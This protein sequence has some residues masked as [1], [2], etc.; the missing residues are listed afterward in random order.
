MNNN[1]I[2]YFDIARSVCVIYI[3]CFWHIGDYIGISYPKLFTDITTGVLATFTF[4]SGLF[5]SKK[6]MSIC[7][8]YKR[9][10]S[11]F[12]FLF[13]IACIT[14]YVAGSIKTSSQLLLAVTG[15]SCFMPPQPMTLWYFCM[16]IVFYFITPFI[17]YK[18][19]STKIL[20]VRSILSFFILTLMIKICGGDHRIPQYLVFY[21]LGFFVPLDLFK[22]ERRACLALMGGCLLCVI[23]KYYH[24][25]VCTDFIFPLGVI[26]LLI[27]SAYFLEKIINVF[28]KKTFVTISYLSMAAYLFHRQWYGIFKIIFMKDGQF[29]PYFVVPIMI[30]SLLVIAWIIQYFYDKTFKLVKN[31]LAK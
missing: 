24:S 27:A 26:C 29:L 17:L 23:S 4:L 7:E 28:M 31:E 22:K 8:F 9:R 25:K 13:L 14:Y 11:R 19:S 18:A 1:R 12:F 2:L 5:L 15:L 30:F 10:L 16:L 6:R 21:L 20:L 3:I